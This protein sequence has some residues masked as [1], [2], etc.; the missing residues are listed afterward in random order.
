MDKINYSQKENINLYREYDDKDFNFIEWCKQFMNITSN[1]ID[2]ENNNKGVCS[3]ILSKICNNV[4]TFDNTDNDI[5]LKNIDINQ[6]DNI[7]VIKNTNVDGQ[8]IKNVDFIRI[9]HDELIELFNIL[10]KCEDTLINNNY[11]P[12]IFYYDSSNNI[13]KIEYETII[14]Y[15]KDL[16]Y[17]VINIVNVNNYLLAG[18]HHL[19]AL[20]E[21]IHDRLYNNNNININII[22]G[23][24]LIKLAEYYIN[25]N[26]YIKAFDCLTNQ[27]LEK[28]DNKDKIYEYISKIAFHIDKNDEGLNACENLIL[29]DTATNK[30]E[31]LL[32][33]TKYM[34]RLPFKKI[35]HLI[36][37]YNEE[38]NSSTPSIIPYNDGYKCNIRYVN[39]YIN[40]GNYIA[41]ENIVR[42]KNV[43]LTLDNNLN[44]LTNQKGKSEHVEL[45][46]KN[47]IP[48]FNNNNVRGLEDVRLFVNNLNKNTNESHIYNFFATSLEY[49]KSRIPQ[50]C[51]GEYDINTGIINKIRVLKINEN[52]QCE[53]N[54]I[55]LMIDNEL[56]FIYSFTPFKFYHVNKDTT[57]ITL[58]KECNLTNKNLSE[59]RGSAPLISY[60]KGWLG[61]IH[62]VYYNKNRRY[63]HR[64]IWFDKE[65]T[66]IKYSKLFIFENINIEYNLSIC[67][68][69]DGLLMTYSIYDKCSK[70]G[71]ID[72]NILDEYLTL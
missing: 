12:F 11:P 22:S 43:I 56:F 23:E 30:N 2:I 7:N 59:F 16:G 34:K 1:F 71:L 33:Y 4:Y 51:H 29:S 55:P 26:E 18:D 9:K 8:N 44:T 35:I 50:M 48:P 40:N 6:I 28:L 17:R 24:K 13:N 62:Q 19:R 72:Y 14:N 45:D 69:N 20:S 70:I 25:H 60:K 52:L 49:N 68:S 3:C 57:E 42:T 39:Y 10:K 37:D 53:K 46:D 64:F 61:T 41:K 67:H 58:V 27:T 31:M 32:C 5:L 63:F 47:I 15:I 21:N 65:F 36:H 54:W 66:T 38:Y